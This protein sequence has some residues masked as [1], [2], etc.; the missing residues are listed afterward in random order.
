MQAVDIETARSR[1]GFA[2]RCAR[3]RRCTRARSTSK[4]TPTSIRPLRRFAA[5]LSVIS[6][7]DLRPSGSSTSGDRDTSRGVCYRCQAG[8][9]TMMG[10]V[11]GKHPRARDFHSAA[12]TDAPVIARTVFRSSPETSGEL[13]ER[14]ASPMRP[15]HHVIGNLDFLGGSFRTE[16]DDHDR[17]AH[18][19]P[20]VPAVLVHRG[21]RGAHLGRGVAHG[22]SM[23]PLSASAL[24]RV[25]PSG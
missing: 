21:D 3:R 9:P 5:S 25:L 18:L 11:R 15:S 8:P 14:R 12:R 20:F 23:R 7:A 19:H 6:D 24:T 22:S 2:L 4:S 16:A 17:S 1:P 13:T 10:S